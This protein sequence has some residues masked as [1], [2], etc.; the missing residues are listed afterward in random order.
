MIGLD[1]GLAER[2]RVYPQGV[3]IKLAEVRGTPVFFPKDPST[4]AK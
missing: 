3:T 2:V 4:G 1:G